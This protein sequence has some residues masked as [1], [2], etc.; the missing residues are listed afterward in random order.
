MAPKKKASPKT[1][2]SKEP[3]R[4]KPGSKKVGVPT[5]AE[6]KAEN[7]VVFAAVVESAKKLQA[8][9]VEPTKQKGKTVVGSLLGGVGSKLLTQDMTQGGRPWLHPRVEWTEELGQ[10]LYALIATG[11]SLREISEMEGMPSLIQLAGWTAENTHG[12]ADL[13]ARAKETLVPIYE[14]LAETIAANPNPVRLKTRKQIVTKDGDVVWV[15]EYRDT[16]GVERSKLALQGIQW[17]LGH[18]KPKKHG[19]RP[20]SGD[21]SGS[22]QLE[23]LFNALKAGPK[24]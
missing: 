21:K 13:R 7:K 19:P 4:R 20:E 9:I 23:G 3:V 5:R 12:F 17:A 14:E 10:A 22:E 15:T 11:H 18:L 1:P 2:A 8:E 6:K 24:S 16:D